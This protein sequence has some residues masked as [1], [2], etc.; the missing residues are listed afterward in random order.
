MGKVQP[1]PRSHA[2][3]RRGAQYPYSTWCGHGTMKLGDCMNTVH[4]L[5]IPWL[6]TLPATASALLLCTACGRS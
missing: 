4:A 1:P 5:S 3:I 2:V 6:A